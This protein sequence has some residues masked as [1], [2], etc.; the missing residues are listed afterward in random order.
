MN[1]IAA[2]AASNGLTVSAELDTG[3]YHKGIKSY[4]REIQNLEKQNALRRHDFHGERNYCLDPPT[5]PPETS[6]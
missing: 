1:A 3:G 4:D 5:P 6:E 2:T